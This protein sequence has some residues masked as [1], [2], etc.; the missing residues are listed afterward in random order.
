MKFDF[1]SQFGAL[2]SPPIF[3]SFEKGLRILGH[4]VRHNADDGDVAVIWSVL[5]HGRMKPNQQVFHSYRNKN[6]PVIVLEV[7]TLNRYVTWKIGINGINRGSFDYGMADSGRRA[8]I[9]G[10]NLK[11]WRDNAGPILLCSQHERSQQWESMPRMSD[12][13]YQTAELIKKYTSKKIIIRNHPRYPVPIPHGCQRSAN[14]DFLDDLKTAHAVINYCS[15]PGIESVIEGV[16]VFVGS[17]SLAYDVAN[18]ISMLEK[19]NDPIK[20]DRSDWLS[21]LAWSEWTQAEMENGIPQKLI[22]EKLY[23]IS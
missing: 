10:L 18:D 20:P 16:P 15:G 12:W 3:E 9:L 11:P 6:K 4:D 7:G 13:L 2:N 8:N 22:I 5:W 17:P 19:I 23:P 14:K 21:R 1:Y